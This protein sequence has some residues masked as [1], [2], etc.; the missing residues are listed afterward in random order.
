MLLMPPALLARGGHLRLFSQQQRVVL[1]GQCAHRSA[2]SE[3]RG[4]SW[5]KARSQYCARF[6]YKQQ[7]YHVG[8]FGTEDAAARA[9]DARLRAVCDDKTRLKR[10]LNFPT[11]GEMA[12][13]ESLRQARAH[14]LSKNAENGTKEKESMHRLQNAFLASPQALSY[15][16]TPV[17]GFSRID[18]VFLAKDFEASGIPLQL[19]S[20]TCRGKVYA[21]SNTRGYEG[22]M[23][24]LIPLDRDKFWAVPGSM[25][26]QTCLSMTLGSA[27]DSSWQVQDVGILLESCWNNPKDFPH[28]TLEEATEQCFHMHA[29]ELHA[30]MLLAKLVSLATRDCK[31]RKP[32][33]A[34]P[35]VDSMLTRDGTHWRVQE[36]ASNLQQRGYI[37]KMS[38][39][40]GALGSIAYAST[41]FDILLASILDNGRLSGLFIFPVDV[42]ARFGA[43]GHKPTHLPLH[44]P[45]HLA[46]KQATRLKY[47]W[48]LEYFVDLRT[49]DGEAVLQS[50]VRSRINCLLSAATIKK[51]IGSCH[52]LDVM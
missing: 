16:I 25:V 50:R 7:K 26:T 21:F 18:A 14:G 51:S 11:L 35:A 31:L 49:W 24:F 23:L 30:H 8:F 37:A 12:F 22:M 4:V 15:T 52:S 40:G 32:A 39:Y 33:F 10:S 43:V 45:W 5:D 13:S 41:D 1:P 2:S 42:L 34:C 9:Y 17:P 46:K 6:E 47:A 38:R 19:K 28:I 27:R 48:Q 44:P 36:K 29:M 20:A 3:F